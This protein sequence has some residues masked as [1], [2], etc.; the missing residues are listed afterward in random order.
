M[1]LLS[2]HIQD[3]RVTLLARAM[4]EGEPQAIANTSEQQKKTVATLS[5]AQQ[6]SLARELLLSIESQ[7]ILPDELHDDNLVKILV[8]L[9]FGD[10]NSN[11]ESF[12]QNALSHTG[13]T[14][15]IDIYLHG[16]YQSEL[17]IALFHQMFDSPAK[18]ASFVL[19]LQKPEFL[20]EFV[21]KMLGLAWTEVNQMSF[22]EKTNYLSAWIENYYETTGKSYL[23][24][25]DI[26]PEYLKI[27]TGQDLLKKFGANS[28]FILVL[29][30]LAGQ[31]MSYLQLIPLDIDDPSRIQIYAF[32]ILVH[33]KIVAIMS[34]LFFDTLTAHQNASEDPTR[35][36]QLA[37]FILSG[38]NS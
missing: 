10:C 25:L 20:V 9:A 36:N 1:G 11:L 2:Q 22:K 3:I 16:T 34:S 29:N 4:N 21:Q 8:F 26:H 23:P 38:F 13:D 37:S 14:S 18:E 5:Q 31:V 30:T 24:G 6:I 28:A 19:A 17:M 15:L 7:N 27:K 33:L 12:R 32:K 35:I